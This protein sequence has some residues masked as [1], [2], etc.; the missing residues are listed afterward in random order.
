MGFSESIQLK[1]THAHFELKGTMS[2]EYGVA[3]MKNAIEYCLEKKIER[4][5][6]SSCS[7]VF[8]AG[9]PSR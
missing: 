7:S 6:V 1:D 9:F 2:F 5:L 3:E 4:L 8:H